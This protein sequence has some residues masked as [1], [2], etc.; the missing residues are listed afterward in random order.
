MRTERV[1]IS[2][3]PIDPNNKRIN[4]FSL[5]FEENM[6]TKIKVYKVW[7]K[8]IFRLLCHQFQIRILSESSM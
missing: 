1:C 8:R 6:V 5:S 7:V 2:P 4:L 3:N